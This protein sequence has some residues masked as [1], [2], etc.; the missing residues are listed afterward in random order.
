MGIFRHNIK[1]IFLL[2]HML[3][4]KTFPCLS[5]ENVFW[6]LPKRA[7]VAYASICISRHNLFC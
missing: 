7:F 5:E 6:V 1:Q 3:Q 2:R 4:A